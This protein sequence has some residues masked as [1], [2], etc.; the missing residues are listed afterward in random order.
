MGGASARMGRDKATIQL[1]GRTLQERCVAALSDAGCTTIWLVGARVLD[2]D[3]CAGSDRPA[4]GDGPQ[5]VPWPDSEPGAGPFAALA[6][7]IS[8]GPPRDLMVLP[9]DLPLIDSAAV[10]SF[11]AAAE[12]ASGDVVLARIDGRQQL[13]SGLWRAGVAL[14]PLPWADIS[15]RRGLEG[16]TVSYVDVDGRFADVDTPEELQASQERFF[17]PPAR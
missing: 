7:L 10:S 6:G 3:L 4:D 1:G 11:L 12:A 8:C 9:C 13:T 14:P 16:I 17:G 15:M 5:L 2:P